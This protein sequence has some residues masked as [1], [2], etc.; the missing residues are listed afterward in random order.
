MMLRYD[1]HTHSKYSD[2]EYD[3]KG[4]ASRAKELGFD[5]IAITDH[6]NLDSWK[7]IDINNY[8]FNVIKGVE[9][10]IYYNG[11]NVHILG[12]YLNDGGNYEELENFLSKIREYRKERAYKVIELLKK[13]NIEIT[14]EEVAVMADG[15]IG[16]PHIAQAIIN[17]YSERNY[18]IDDVFDKFIGNNAPA[19]VKSFNFETKDAIAMLK[20]NHC[21]AVLAH[22]L[23]SNKYDYKE[24]LKLGIEGIEVYYPYLSGKKYEEVLEF[25]KKNNLIITGGSDYH[26]PNIRNTMG[27]EYLKNEELSSFLKAINYNHKNV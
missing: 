1:L 16:R 22:P 20:R 23:F 11:V 15:A 5:G 18:T 4:N 2:G 13:C 26:G 17:K 6:D 7:D 14:Y 8:N 10:S 21:L 9:L 3:I 19:Y 27:K 24:I 25:A 12:Y